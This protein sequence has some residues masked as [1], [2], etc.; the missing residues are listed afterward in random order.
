MSGSRNEVAQLTAAN[1][2]D[3]VVF[4]VIYLYDLRGQHAS[5]DTLILWA[6]LTVNQTVPFVSGLH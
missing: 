1:S 4:I 5:S 2:D 3:I 6:A